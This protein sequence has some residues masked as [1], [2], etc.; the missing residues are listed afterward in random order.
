MNKEIKHNQII[1]ELIQ[2]RTN[3]VIHQLYHNNITRAFT[4][5]SF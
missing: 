3:V 4:F 5:L 1:D 2:Y